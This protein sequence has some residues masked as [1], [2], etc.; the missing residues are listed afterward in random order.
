[1]Q[2]VLCPIQL[3]RKGVQI[4]PLIF[5]NSLIFKVKYSKLTFALFLIKSQRILFFKL[6][7]QAVYKE[8]SHVQVL[9]QWVYDDTFAIRVQ[10]YANIY[11]EDLDPTNITC[12]PNRAVS[13]NVTYSHM[14]MQITVDLC[15]ERHNCKRIWKVLLWYEDSTYCKSIV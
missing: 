5:G 7:R 1:M 3:I 8:R 11:I 6:T 14:Y 15:I 10:S 9:R 2:I 12:H 4:L 13:F